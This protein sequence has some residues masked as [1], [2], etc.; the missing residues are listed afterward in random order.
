[1]QRVQ[2]KAEK[3]K[4]ANQA[5][6]VKALE[7]HIDRVVALQKGENESPAGATQQVVW[8]LRRELEHNKNIQIFASKLADGQVIYHVVDLRQASENFDPGFI[9]IKHVPGSNTAIGQ[10]DAA[11]VKEPVQLRTPDEVAMSVEDPGLQHALKFG[12]RL[13]TGESRA[14]S[15]EESEVM[16]EETD[17]QMA[18][19]EE[20]VAHKFGRPKL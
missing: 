8:R 12:E 17:R 20:L 9:D 7:E 4:V 15:P 11:G 6:T 13:R 2:E 5:T 19:L 1:M 3:R 18:E 16:W 10:S 14:L